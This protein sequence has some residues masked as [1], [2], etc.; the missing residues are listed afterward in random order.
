MIPRTRDGEFSNQIQALAPWCSNLSRRAHENME[1][2]ENRNSPFELFHDF[3][4]SQ[5]VDISADGLS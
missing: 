5:K 1:R 3:E 4:T 2:W